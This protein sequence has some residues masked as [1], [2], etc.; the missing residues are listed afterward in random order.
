MSLTPSGRPRSFLNC[1]I[2]KS[3]PWSGWKPPSGVTL[4]HITTVSIEQALATNHVWEPCRKFTDMF[5]T[6]ATENDLPPILLAAFALQESTCNPD[7]LG[8]GGGAF[9]LFQITQ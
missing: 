4:D 1:G 2:S 6:V 9:G 5:E 7:V 3:D 8:D